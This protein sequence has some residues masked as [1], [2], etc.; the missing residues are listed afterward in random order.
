MGAR[1]SL[2]SESEARCGPG[3]NMARGY[4]RE[5]KRARPLLRCFRF[6]ALAAAR[7]TSS[8]RVSYT[9]L[10]LISRNSSEDLESRV[11]GGTGGGGGGQKGT[12]RILVG[13]ATSPTS[14]ED[15]PTQS[16]HL[17]YQMSN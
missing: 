3:A 14:N 16:K 6:R 11:I 9:A 17:L 2:V 10:L 8:P 13:E 4:Y 1:A 12:K 7:S 5:K 15:P